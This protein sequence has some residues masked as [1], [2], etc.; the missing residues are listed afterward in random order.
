M[1]KIIGKT[2]PAEPRSGTVLPVPL[3]ASGQLQRDPS[4]ADLA[5]WRGQTLGQLKGAAKKSAR[6][7]PKPQ[8]GKAGTGVTVKKR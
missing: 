6:K 8:K 7:F 1:T 4:A 2:G 3:A 5:E